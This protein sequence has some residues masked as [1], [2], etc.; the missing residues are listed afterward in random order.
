VNN[1][2]RPEAFVD[3]ELA[4]QPPPGVTGRIRHTFSSLQNSRLEPCR[5]LLHGSH[6]AWFVETQASAVQRCP[7]NKRLPSGVTAPRTHDLQGRVWRRN[8]A[9]YTECAQQ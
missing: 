9:D 8:P 7:T 6:T 3:S 1:A 2:N 4:A 5:R